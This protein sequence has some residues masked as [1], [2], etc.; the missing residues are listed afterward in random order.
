MTSE[1]VTQVVSMLIAAVVGAIIHRFWP[2]GLTLPTTKPATPATP[3]AGDHD[4]P[5]ANLLMQLLGM[6]AQGVLPVPTPASSSGTSPTV[7]PVPGGQP[8]AVNG[9][10]VSVTLTVAGRSIVLPLDSA[11]LSQLLGGASTAPPPTT[12]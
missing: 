9:S 7:V 1:Q 8:A 6:I 12:A 10:P 11:T 3:A 4:R 5:L 2:A